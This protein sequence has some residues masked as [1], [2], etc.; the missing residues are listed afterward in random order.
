LF[1]GVNYLLKEE[2]V[3]A[4]LR[5]VR[6]LLSPGGVFIFDQSTPAN[7]INNADFFEDE[8]ESDAGSWLRQSTY[9]EVDCIHTTRFELTTPEGTFE[10]VH[11]ERAWNMEDMQRMLGEADLD[12]LAAYDGFSLDP[13]DESAE[14]IHWVVEARS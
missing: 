5:E 3:V 13:A 12:V 8:G 2:E 10:E 7:S 9:D 11:L 1:D 4:T 14:R 6:S